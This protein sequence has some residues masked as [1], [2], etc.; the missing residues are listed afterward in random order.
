MRRTG[1]RKHAPATGARAGRAKDQAPRL[2]GAADQ[3]GRLLASLAD[4]F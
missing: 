2:R 3:T 1:K 4:I